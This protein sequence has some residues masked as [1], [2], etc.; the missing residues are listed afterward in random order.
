MRG[1]AALLGLLAGASLAGAT[2][3]AEW[4]R[5]FG[6]LGG[7]LYLRATY[8]D[9]RGQPHP[10]E[11]W[12]DAAGRVVRRTDGKAELH[13]SPAPNGE[14]SYQFRNLARRTAYTL[15]Q[16]NLPRVGVFTDRW[17]VQ[18]L[19]DRPRG[20][21]TL[22]HLNRAETTPAGECAWWRI[23]PTSGAPSEVCWS[24]KLGVPLLMR[25]GGR[26]TFQVQTVKTQGVQ[27][28]AQAL[29]QGWQEFDADEDL[30]PD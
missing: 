26:T 24:A 16:G 17:S 5:A 28:P 9:G 11:F 12:R 29:P 2:S 20:A 4:D 27:V 10:L 19:L 13:F 30:A 15:H 21:F 7:A 22:T 25:S 8:L 1:R 3:P 23:A 6:N 14:D 18:H